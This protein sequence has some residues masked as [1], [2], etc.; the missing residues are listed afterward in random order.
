M[1]AVRSWGR[2][3]GADHLVKRP[4]FLDQALDV[5]RRG[6]EPSIL[7]HGRGRSYGDVCLNENGRLLVTDALDRIISFDKERGILRAEAGL[8]IDSL[9]RTVVPHG[10]FVPVTPGT[11]FVTLGGVVA[12]DVHG[13]NHETAGC[14]G[15]HISKI[16]LALSS[17]DLLTLSLGEN[18]ALF[19]ATIGGLGLTGLILWIEIQLAPIA[20][21]L[22][23][24]E[25]IP[26]RDLDHFFVVAQ[27]SQAWP[28]GVGWV[29][30]LAVG[31]GIGRG[32]Y[33]RG[34]HAEKGELAAHR[35]PRLSVPFD[36]PDGLLNQYSIRAFNSLYR[37]RSGKKKHQIQHYDAFFYPLDAIGS[38]NRLYGRRGFFQHQSVVPM[39]HAFDSVRKMLSFCSEQR[40]GSFLVVLK[41]FGDRRSPGLLSFPR[42]GA[43]LALDFPNRGESTRRLLARMESEVMKA[44]GRLYP[45]KDATMSAE[46]FQAG[47]PDWVKLESLRDPAINSDF[48]RR[49]TGAT[50]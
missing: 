19:G 4:A 41:L 34:R 32:C 9:L 44:G 49:V 33:I 2:L 18:A 15:S 12:N 16:G 28:Y 25:T 38:W 47:Y 27:E 22:I 14:F 7:C 26:I 11:K 1:S 31:G 10:W 45:A 46:T 5:L 36:V 23:E 29:D 39:T 50:A 48:W 30:A 35:Q 40:E 24:S 13:K 6:G 37:Y 42:P 17:G 21:A 3:R 43:T 20:S 8:T